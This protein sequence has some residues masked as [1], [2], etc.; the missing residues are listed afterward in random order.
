MECWMCDKD[1]TNSAKFY[2]EDRVLCEKCFAEETAFA[3]DINKP[4]HYTQGKIEPIDFIES[5]KL[6]FNEGNV[7]KYI[8]RYKHKGTPLKDLQKIKFYV[9]RLIKNL[10][11]SENKTWYYQAE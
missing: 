8:V 6:S 10:D 5:H 9:D 3:D 1:I 11:K 7:V 2:I 4:A